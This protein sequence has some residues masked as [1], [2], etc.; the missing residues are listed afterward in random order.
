MFKV[1]LNTTLHIDRMCTEAIKGMQIGSIFIRHAYS[2]MG[3]T[4]KR[5]AGG[6]VHK[7]NHSYLFLCL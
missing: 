7:T 3:Q 2:H 6:R 1:S 5:Q 4:D